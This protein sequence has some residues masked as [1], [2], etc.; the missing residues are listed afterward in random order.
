[1]DGACNSRGKEAELTAH[2]LSVNN[3]PLL[4]GDIQIS[5][6]PLAPEF[7]FKF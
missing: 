4:D 2:F 1:M 3:A 6:N 5:V 7:S